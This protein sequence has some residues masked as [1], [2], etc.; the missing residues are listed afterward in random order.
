MA[1]KRDARG[2][3]VPGEFGAKRDA[4]GRFLPSDWQGPYKR[5]GRA[6]AKGKQ[7]KA[8]DFGRALERYIDTARPDQVYRLYP[9]LAGV[10]RKSK[11][12]RIAVGAYRSRITLASRQDL[13][14]AL[15]EM[16]EL[17][18]WDD[19]SADGP[20]AR[21][22]VEYGLRN[23]EWEHDVGDTESVERK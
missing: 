8:A 3:F 19:M 13:A 22:L 23:P 6:Y 17:D 16:N 11:G 4:R 7:I 2:R 9:E 21:L 5:G 20:L 14:R 10:P 18:E 15:E 12:Y 1:R